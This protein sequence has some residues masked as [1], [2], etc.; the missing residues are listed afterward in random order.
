MLS[1]QNMI[2]KKELSLG[3]IDAQTTLRNLDAVYSMES[4]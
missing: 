4:T 2:W 3:E 1:Y